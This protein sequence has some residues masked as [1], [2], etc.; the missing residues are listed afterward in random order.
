MNKKKII[1]RISYGIDKVVQTVF[2]IVFII[3]LLGIYDTWAVYSH[4]QDRSTLQYKPKNGTL[5]NQDL[6]D[7]IAWLTLNDSKI[8]YPIMQ[9]TTN[10]TYLNTDPYGNYSLSGS[11]F[12]DSR[13]N[14]DFS[15][16]YNLVYGH[17]MNDDAMFGALDHWFD[18]DYYGS[19]LTGT[20]TTASA[21]YQ[22]DV[23]GIESIDASEDKVFQPGSENSGSSM[24]KSNSDHILALSTCQ[25]PESTMRTVLFCNMTLIYQGEVKITK[26]APEEKGNRVGDKIYSDVKPVKPNKNVLDSL[27]KLIAD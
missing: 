27:L 19:H 18:K 23:I 16:P 10:E 9:G 3:G 4:A 24:L 11:I 2:F 5:L 15:D 8:D 25:L 21:I 12:L 14:A 20:L 1:K 6:K 13:N 7:N 26:E 17:H 22:L